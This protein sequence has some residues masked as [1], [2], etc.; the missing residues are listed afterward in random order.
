M[1]GEQTYTQT[2]VP[3]QNLQSPPVETGFRGVNL[4]KYGSAIPATDLL[5]MDN[6]W[7]VGNVL[8]SRPGKQ[9]MLAALI[10]IGG[11]TQIPYA[12]T[13]FAAADT[14]NPPNI[15]TWL[16]FVAGSRLWMCQADITSPATELLMGGIGG[17][18]F[19]ING[20]TARL[21]VEGP[22]LYIIDGVGPL[23]K[24][25]I[26]YVS[27]TT[28]YT[29]N[30]VTALVAPSAGFT[31]SLTNQVI[32]PVNDASVWASLPALNSVYGTLPVTTNL[33]TNTAN[34][35]GTQTSTDPP[36]I[37]YQ[38]GG[39]T[40]DFLPINGFNYAKFDRGNGSEW[41]DWDA[42]IP[43]YYQAIQSYTDLVLVV[44]QGGLQV[45]SATRAFINTDIG[46][47]LNITSGTG[48][49]PGPYLISN[50]T[51][52]IA[53]LSTSAGT[54][55]STA[56][57]GTLKGFSTVNM[58]ANAR[59][60]NM[61]S[62]YSASAAGSIDI[63]AYPEAASVDSLP[64]PFQYSDLAYVSAGTYNGGTPTTVISSVMRP[65]VAGDVSKSITCKSGTTWNPGGYTILSVAGGQATVTGTMCS[66]AATN[67][68]AVLGLDQGGTRWGDHNTVIIN[69]PPSQIPSAFQD[70][71]VACQ[72]A[73]QV[74]ITNTFSF[75][76][77]ATDFQFLRM[78]TFGA[79]AQNGVVYTPGPSIAPVD[80][81]LIP[82]NVPGGK[83]KIAAQ[84]GTGGNCVGG[85]WIK[86][87]YTGGI[88]TRTDLAV[89]GANT[90]TVSSAGTP[91]QVGDAN[92]ILAVQGGN[93]WTVGTYKI[94]SVNAG[95][96]VAT[97]SAAVASS[98]SATGGVGVVASVQDF[99]QSSTLSI[100]YSAPAASGNI[101]MRLGFLQPG[102]PFTNISW[103]NKVT[104]TSDGTAFFVDCSNIPLVVRQQTAYLFVQILADLPTTVDL[105]NL[106]TLGAIAQGGNLSLNGIYGGL[107]ADYYYQYTEINAANDAVFFADVI[108]SDPSPISTP[109]MQPN[110]IDDQVTFP[111][112]V[113]VNPAT[114]H[115]GVYRGGG[116]VNDG[117]LHLIGRLPL[118]SDVSYNAGSTVFAYTDLVLSTN[119]TKVSS[120]AR[121]FVSG[122]VGGL[123][124]IVSGLGWTPGTYPV[125]AV[126][127]GVA[128]LGTILAGTSAGTDASTGGTGNLIQ[129]ASTIQWN[130][131]TRTFTD[132]TPDS[133]LLS[134]TPVFLLTGR[135]AAPRGCTSIAVWQNRICLAKGATLYASWLMTA[136]NNTGLYFNTINV[137]D[138]NDT[139]QAIKGGVFP[140]G[141]IN[142]PILSLVPMPAWL[143]IIK[144]RSLYMFAGQ[145]AGSFVCVP[146]LL[147]AG[148]GSVAPL[149]SAIVNQRIWFLAADGVR[150]YDGGEMCVTRSKDIEPVLNPGVRNLPRLSASAL[151]QS[152]MVYHGERLYLVVPGATT[153][154]FPT[155]VW[156][157]DPWTA[158]GGGWTG[159]WLGWN[160]TSAASL[161]E[162]SN[163]DDLYWASRDGQ[164]YKQTGQ[165]DK[166]LSSSSAT[167][168]SVAFESRRFGQ[169]VMGPLYWRLDRA[170]YVNADVVTNEANVVVTVG[171]NPVGMQG[172]SAGGGAWSQ[173]Y[174]LVTAGQSDMRLPPRDDAYGENISVKIS[175][176]TVTEFDILACGIESIDASPGGL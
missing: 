110:G 169:E 161:S 44:A 40:M 134:N 107:G 14:S 38:T 157:W 119:G 104:F 102:Q 147:K 30:E 145:D 19:N 120:V 35:G 16:I 174:T 73:N 148:T 103:S 123:V 9:G 6:M 166:A 164:I 97:L 124:Q 57:I 63:V 80:I 127:S 48:F 5:K 37:G 8:K 27:P 156:I 67:G 96:H 58:I 153:D 95:T 77:L 61:S 116:S 114:T 149:A 24:I 49:T 118:A 50:V 141:G 28:A 18:S 21:M 117:Q 142:D 25:N 55:G 88:V 12:L 2:V 1:P 146:H 171:A 22:Y 140:A 139:A 128:T 89:A 170:I 45:S 43:D 7:I 34:V 98:S 159:P 33:N 46:G 82:T 60:F 81:R 41:Y 94:V 59:V 79:Q 173:T 72:T 20:P 29:A 135:T 106:F 87:D 26:P 93:L 126:A 108:E 121:P 158:N 105:T 92:K 165:G 32:D 176:S 154:T 23:Y 69:G 84:S 78:R 13:P 51:N 31:A 65:F 64:A 91:F 172:G 17:T 144:Q 163:T 10:T 53:I 47:I 52:G 160:M 112:P 15:T 162:A 129:P 71:H 132:N 70:F 90:L 83:L 167:A 137:Q 125:S 168:V 130:H 101:P 74:P 75:S 131:T 150:E 99:S 36:P 54:A 56:G 4:Y 155:Q 100:G 151:R 133:S 143:S 66:A 109:P 85:A 86:R 62:L 68:T 39:D 138:P 42:L 76:T 113:A 111:L 136:G 152:F 122:D 115:Y 3:A 11:V 175:A